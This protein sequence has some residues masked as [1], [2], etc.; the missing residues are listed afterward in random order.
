MLVNSLDD[1]VVVLEALSVHWEITA[2]ILETA[3][4][5]TFETHHNHLGAAHILGLHCW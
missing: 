2:C 1:I 4:R 5:G 3:G